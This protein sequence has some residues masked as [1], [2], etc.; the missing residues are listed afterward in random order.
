[1]AA[2]PSSAMTNWQPVA[3]LADILED[4]INKASVGDVKLILL[5]AWGEVFAY[6]DVCP[7]ERYPL[8]QG[9]LDGDVLIC[10]K[11]LWEFE[12]RTGMH[13]S[14]LKLAERN[15]TAYPVRIIDGQVEVDLARATK[16]GS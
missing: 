14:Q 12:I 13:I 11:H 7:H 15:L 2:Q 16:F 4:T 1:M 9:E 8:S 5:K 3:R 10:S 6:E